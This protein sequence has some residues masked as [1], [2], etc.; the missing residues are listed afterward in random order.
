[1]YPF[2][3]SFLSVVVLGLLFNSN[4]QNFDLGLFIYVDGHSSR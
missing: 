2:N 4:W 1:M 3:I